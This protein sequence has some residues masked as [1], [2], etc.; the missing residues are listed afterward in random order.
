MQYLAKTTSQLS[1]SDWEQLCLLFNGSFQREVSVEWFKKK[2][3]STVPSLDCFHGLMLNDENSIVGAMTIIPFEYNYFD[4]NVVFGNLIDLMIHSEYR[5]NILNFKTI[6]EKLLSFVDLKV[7]FIYAV[8]NPNSHLYFMKILKWRDIGKLN[9]YLW[10]VMPSKLLKGNSII[11]TIFKPFNNLAQIALS[12]GTGRVIKPP[13]EKTI[14][15]SFLKYRYTVNYKIISEDKSKSWYRIYDE[16]GIVTAYIIDI[17]PLQ[18]R[19]LAKTVRAIYDREKNTVA[20]IMYISNT[21]LGAFNIL[22]APSKFEPRPL[23]LIGRIINSS[24]IDNR[25]F[26]LSNWRFNLSD[27][28]VR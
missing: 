24:N 6:Y 16:E 15:D 7:D 22:K 23:P 2:Y 3:K 17:E 10:P 11:D 14:S 8:P 25:I 9:Y 13:I 5:K 26:E 21:K 27:F 4:R 18:A 28:D 12:H 19:W 1:N 20:V